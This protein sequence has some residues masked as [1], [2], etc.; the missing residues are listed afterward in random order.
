MGGDD[1]SD[2]I[3]YLGIMM[4]MMLIIQF[5]QMVLVEVWD[6]CHLQ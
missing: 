4:M 1:G 6:E 3:Y 5:L 2:V